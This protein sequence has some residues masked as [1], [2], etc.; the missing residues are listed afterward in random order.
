MS[1]LSPL[2][3]LFFFF[4]NDT[5]TTEIYTL[6][7]HDALPILYR[8]RADEP[9]IVRAPRPAV[10]PQP[11]LCRDC[12]AGGLVADQHREYPGICDRLGR[13]ADRGGTRRRC[14]PFNGRAARSRHAEQ[15]VL[16]AAPPR[17]GR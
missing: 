8:R 16:P 5:A 17:T 9:Q 12:R 7:L 11:G 6:S 15:Q 1:T 10:V 4:F 13:D 14:E 3:H 2:S